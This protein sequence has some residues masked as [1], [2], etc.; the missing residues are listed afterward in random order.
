MR[1]GI[2]ADWEFGT[3]EQ[4]P[5]LRHSEGSNKGNLLP[6]Q[7]D[8]LSGLLVLDG[9]TLSP[10]FNPQ[11]FDYRV[12]LSDD[13]VGQISFSPTIANSMQTISILKDE[14]TS[15]PSVSSGDTVAINLNTAPEPTLITIARHYRI[16]VIRRSGL[17]AT[18]NSDPF[19]AI[20]WMRGKVLR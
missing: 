8:M 7:Q 9:L 19:G 20:G 10:A 17:E 1:D 5:I 14:K 15:L 13:S 2:R 3:S 11:T 6:G 4:Y 12:N 18:I 16:W